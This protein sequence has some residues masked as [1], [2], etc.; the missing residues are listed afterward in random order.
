MK[1]QVYIITEAEDDLFEIYQHVA[2]NDSISHAEKLI[3]KLE[4]TC[5]SLSALPNR[6]HVPPELERVAVH[7]YLEIHYKP[8]RIIYQVISHRVFIHC[9]LDGRRDLGELLQKRLLR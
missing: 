2:K 1:Y 3:D 9:V 7:D 6:G 5:L 4:E 8:Y